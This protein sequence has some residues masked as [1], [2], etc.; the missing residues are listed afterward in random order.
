VTK[1][2]RGAGRG[3][4]RS[5]RSRVGTAHLMAKI[6]QFV[7]ARRTPQSDSSDVGNP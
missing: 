1:A 7:T 2:A 4:V 5:I 6:L 3:D